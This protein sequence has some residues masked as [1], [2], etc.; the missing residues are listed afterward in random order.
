MVWLINKYDMSKMSF[1]LLSG[2]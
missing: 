2:A 1:N